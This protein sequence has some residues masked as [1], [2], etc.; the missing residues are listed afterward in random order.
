[1]AKWQRFEPA[2]VAWWATHE[3]QYFSKPNILIDINV[4]LYIKIFIFR[5]F[6]KER[7]KLIEQVDLKYKIFSGIMSDKIY[8]HKWESGKEWMEKRTF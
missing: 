5:K 2:I 6:Y 3:L 8:L 4:I 7:I 1:M